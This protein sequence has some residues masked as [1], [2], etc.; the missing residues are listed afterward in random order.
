MKIK[1]L[2]FII[3]ILGFYPNFSDAV[4]CLLL[5]LIEISNWKT[6]FFFILSFSIRLQCMSISGTDLYPPIHFHPNYTKGDGQQLSIVV[7]C[8]L[9]ILFFILWCLSIFSFICCLWNYLLFFFFLLWLW[10]LSCIVRISFSKMIFC[11]W[12]YYKDFFFNINV[13][14]YIFVLL[15]K[16]F[17]R[18]YVLF[19]FHW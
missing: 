13:Y 4:A 3:F 17:H 9:C 19:L 1:I 18:F 16:A 11:S 7:A 12:L 15:L 10:H 5:L 2:V 8:L 14:I 6:F